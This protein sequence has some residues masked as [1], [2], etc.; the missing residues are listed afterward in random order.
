MYRFNAKDPGQSL[1]TPTTVGVIIII[2]FIDRTQPGDHMSYLTN[3]KD[4]YE[5]QLNN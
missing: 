5:K 3:S 4:W 1:Y 2:Y